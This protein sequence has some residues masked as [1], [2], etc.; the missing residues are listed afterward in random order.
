MKLTDKE[1]NSYIG[2]IIITMI[3]ALL[4]I[5]FVSLIKMY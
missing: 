3:S 1:V 5:L 2:L 4:A